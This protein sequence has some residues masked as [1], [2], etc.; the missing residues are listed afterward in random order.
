MK[1]GKRIVWLALLLALA[2]QLTGCGPIV[3]ED[4]QSVRVGSIVHRI[5]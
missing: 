2:A 5:L 1:I 3:V 4:A